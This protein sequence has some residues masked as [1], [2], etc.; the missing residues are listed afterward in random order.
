MKSVATGVLRVIL[1][2]VFCFCIIGVRKK[3]WPNAT[4]KSSRDKKNIGTG[5]WFGRNNGARRVFSLLSIFCN[6]SPGEKSF[7]LVSSVLVIFFVS[8][9][10]CNT[11][12]RR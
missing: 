6:K 8:F 12:R 2:K 4:A 1:R 3:V 7:R 9:D 5:V 11:Y 10:T